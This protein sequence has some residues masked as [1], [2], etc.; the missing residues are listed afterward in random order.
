MPARSTAA[1]TARR[2]RASRDWTTG[3]EAQR[4]GAVSPTAPLSGWRS[5]RRPQP[6]TSSQSP[7][8]PVEVFLEAVG[9]RRQ[10]PRGAGGSA[11][12]VDPVGRVVLV[13]VAAA[14]LG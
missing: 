14:T 10:G 3:T 8:D 5:R 6:A 12:T 2:W 9:R 1:R 4:K 13:V 11:G 7:H